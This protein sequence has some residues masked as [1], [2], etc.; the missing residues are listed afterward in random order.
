MRKNWLNKE[1]IPELRKSIFLYSILS[2]LSFAIVYFYNIELTAFFSLTS[3]SRFFLLMAFLPM[4]ALLSRPYKESNAV[5]FIVAI[6]AGDGYF[7]L[8]TFGLWILV[9]TVIAF[10]MFL[11][12]ALADV[13]LLVGFSN[14]VF[15]FSFFC[16]IFHLVPSQPKPFAVRSPILLGI[17]GGKQS[18]KTVYIGMLHNYLLNN[19]KWNVQCANDISSA[20]ITKIMEGL[21]NE[22]WPVP[23]LH[24]QG[25]AGLSEDSLIT[26]HYQRTTLLDHYLG[27]SYFTLNIADPSGEVFEGSVSEN[28]T[29]EQ[30]TF[31]N[32]LALS[33]G[34]LYVIDYSMSREREKLTEQLEFVLTRIKHESIYLDR[35]GRITIPIAI[36]IS[37]VDE[38]YDQLSRYNK[39]PDDFLGS[40]FGSQNVRVLKENVCRYKIFPFS[41]IGIKKKGGVPV[42]RT[43]NVNGSFVPD[44]ELK[45]FGLFEPI[46]WLLL[47]SWKYH[48][49]RNRKMKQM[50]RSKF[51]K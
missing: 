44:R 42:P 20:Y 47:E 14:W 28:L 32:L 29:K 9:I 7:W 31:F 50:E 3:R 26:F 39:S 8:S 45:S 21:W 27:E 30:D 51:W 43:H 15:L 35:C 16:F 40:L 19:K 4:F 41:S 1:V 12:Y 36:G 18:G 48:M 13:R 34:I 46:R 10:V 49:K 5:G 37:K 6:R 38:I 33:T 2:I 25:G 24:E 22:R 23:T 17:G 11:L